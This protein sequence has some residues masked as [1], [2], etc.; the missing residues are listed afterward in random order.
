MCEGV[1]Y[2]TYLMSTLM[3]F[4]WVT[5]VSSKEPCISSGA[6]LAETEDGSLEAV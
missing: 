4:S 3:G 6:G 2:S 1:L 5:P